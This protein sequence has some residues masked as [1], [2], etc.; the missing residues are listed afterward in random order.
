MGGGGGVI[1]L[2]RGEL[3]INMS[4]LKEAKELVRRG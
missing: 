4:S 3:K 2:W 1:D